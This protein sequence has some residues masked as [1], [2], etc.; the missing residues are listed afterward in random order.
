[1]LKTALTLAVGYVLGAKAG[2]ERYG[3]IKDLAQQG[4]A[5]L[6]ERAR[7]RADTPSRSR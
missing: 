6:E 1:M 3:Q 7:E 2:Q 4:A 5:R